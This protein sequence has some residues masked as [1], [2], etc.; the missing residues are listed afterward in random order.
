[1]K[2]NVFLVL[3]IIVLLSSGCSKKTENE[4]AV[5]GVKAP[6]SEQNSAAVSQPAAATARESIALA[7]TIKTVAEKKDYLISQA[8]T[9][10]KS[11]QFEQVAEVGQYILQYVDKDS[12]KAKDLIE[13]AKAQLQAQ[14][15]NAV[16]GVKQTLD[17]FNN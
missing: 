9:F 1:M 5:S 2:Q 13:K 4:Q 8:E 6:A 16:N 15:K 14:A 3:M 17:G 10:Y 12:V 7:Q 11:K